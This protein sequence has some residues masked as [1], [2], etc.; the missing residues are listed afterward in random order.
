[1]QRENEGVLVGRCGDLNA[2]HSPQRSE[3]QPGGLGRVK[4]WVTRVYRGDFG[5]KVSP[6]SPAWPAAASFPQFR[7]LPGF[8]SEN[9]LEPTHPSLGPEWCLSTFWAM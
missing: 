6:G 5:D 7:G 2:L 4:T 9:S 8:L 1:M 3:G